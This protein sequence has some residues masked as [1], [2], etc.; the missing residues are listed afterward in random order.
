[1]SNYGKTSDVQSFIICVDTWESS[2]K[3][4]MH[5]FISKDLNVLEEQGDDKADISL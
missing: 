4:N 2:V 1:M 5:K 3:L